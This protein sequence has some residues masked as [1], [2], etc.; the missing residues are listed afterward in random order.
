[1]MS[2]ISVHGYSC[3]HSACKAGHANIVQ[4]L[5]IHMNH[6]LIQH[7]SSTGISAIMIARKELEKAQLN[8]DTEK[9]EKYVCICGILEPF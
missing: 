8:S 5:S 2:V 7:K 1:M 4:F 9:V 3:L 6:E